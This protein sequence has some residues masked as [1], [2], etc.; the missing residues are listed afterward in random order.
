MQLQRIPTQG[1]NCFHADNLMLEL[2]YFFLKIRTPFYSK[3][4]RCIVY[5]SLLLFPLMG[6]IGLECTGPSCTTDASSS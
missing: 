6:H 3:L 4:K 2:F 5:Y 1:I